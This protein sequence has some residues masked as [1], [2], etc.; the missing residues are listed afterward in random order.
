MGLISI[1]LYSLSKNSNFVFG[2]FLTVTI[3]SF[4]ER[5]YLSEIFDTEYTVSVSVR[6]FCILY[7]YFA[8]VYLLF[9]PVADRCH[10]AGM[11]GCGHSKIARVR[12]YYLYCMWLAPAD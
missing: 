9:I 2:K 4:R 12:A 1:G 7:L 5:V 8:F 11:A 10:A 3:Q 6:Q